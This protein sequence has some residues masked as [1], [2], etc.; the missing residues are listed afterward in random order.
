MRQQTIEP[1]FAAGRRRCLLAALCIGGGL[2]AAAALP[3][4]AQTGDP[5]VDAREAHAWLERIHAAAGQKNFQGTFVVSAGGSVTSSRIA[6][7]CEGRNQFER[8]DSLDGQRRQVLRHND[9]VQTL[10]PASR[11][12]VVENRSMIGGFPALL[13]SS[14]DR[15]VRYYDARPL[16]RDR[17][18]GHEAN[19]LLLKPKD[20]FRFGYRLWAEKSSGLLLRAEVLGAQGEVIEASAFSDVQ[21][22]VRP[23][24]EL[25]LA[26]MKRLDGYRVQRPAFEQVEISREGWQLRDLPPGFKHVSSVRRTIDA[27]SP[28]PAA[29]GA[30]D[31]PAAPAAVLQTIYSDGLTHV[32]VF[33]EPYNAVMHRHELLMAMGATQTLARRQGEWWLTVIGDVPVVTL[34]AFAAALERRP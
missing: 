29:S 14:A 15:I 23:Q 3:A 19:V 33:V 32:S 20:S 13:Q 10:W 12:A 1:W 24:P 17:V 25:V 8:I 26:A 6:H 9:V 30:G 18:A 7:Y 4:R 21:I 11:V 2:W 16:G 34:K 27:A 28:T 5:L 31:A 22:G